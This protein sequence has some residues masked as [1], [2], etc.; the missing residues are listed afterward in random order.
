MKKTIQTLAIAS[1]ALF[2]ITSCDNDDDVTIINEEEVITTVIYTLTNTAD[3]T[4][5]V[6]FR[7]L[8]AD[9]EGPN[10][11]V[12]T[13]IGDITANTNYTGSVQFLNELESPAEDITEE[14]LEEADEHEVFYNATVNGV[15]ITKTDVDPDGNP[16]GLRTTFNTG[17][18]G[19]GNLTIVLRHEP[20]KPNDNTLTGAGGETDVEVTF[21]FQ[22]Q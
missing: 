18:A 19:T 21:D 15:S 1:I 2:T 6:V 9:G 12:E 5:E 16:L 8:D 13:V 7:S 4:D 11:P 14:V 3:A 22:V 20:T 10:D 17:A